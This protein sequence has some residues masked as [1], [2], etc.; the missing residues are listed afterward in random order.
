MV[1]GKLDSDM[2]KNE[3]YTMHY[4]ILYTKKLKWIKDLNI[5]CET[6]KILE[7]N[8]DVKL[9]DIGSGNDFLNLTPKAKATYAK[10]NK[11][12][13]VKLK[14]FCTAKEAI[15]KIKRQP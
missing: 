9:L 7:E 14:S 12:D 4:L 3:S 1:L 2:Q 15:K 11:W 6:I 13:Y 10:V 8:I 5:R